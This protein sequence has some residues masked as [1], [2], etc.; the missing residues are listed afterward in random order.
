MAD[1]IEGIWIL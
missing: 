1:K